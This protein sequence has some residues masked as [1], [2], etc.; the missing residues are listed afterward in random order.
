MS[1]TRKAM[2]GRLSVTW[3]GTATTAAAARSMGR[4]GEG[5]NEPG[6]EEATAPPGPVEPARLLLLDLQLRQ[7]LGQRGDLPL[8]LQELL[9]RHLGLHLRL[10]QLLRLDLQLRLE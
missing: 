9:L 3:G 4:S 2:R 1:S 10:G 8:S 6:P 7:L 5:K